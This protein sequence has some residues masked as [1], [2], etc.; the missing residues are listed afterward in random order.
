MTS[1]Q[2]E[3]VIPKG[4]ATFD[5][6]ERLAIVNLFGAYA[7]HY[8]AGRL[9][10]W[11]ELF[12]ESA[13]VRF[14]NRGRAVTTTL[15]ETIPILKARQETFSAEKDQRRHALN[16]L[17]FDMQ[18]TDEATGRCYFQVFSTRDGGA[19]AVQ[20]TGLYEFTAVKQDTEWKFS[21]WIAHID[22]GGM[23]PAVQT[24][25]STLCICSSDLLEWIRPGSTRT[26][27]WCRTSPPLSSSC[28]VFR[29]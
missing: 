1:V 17:C 18:K 28:Q 2:G 11:R 5:A 13:D 4:D 8:D 3:T 19:P 10:E 9:D 26:A 14:L 20:L 7:Q 24:R 27:L 29:A 22:Q 25:W 12:T 15:A 23:T 6:A 21:R 16:S